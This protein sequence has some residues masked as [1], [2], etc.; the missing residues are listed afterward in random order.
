[1]VVVIKSRK[2]FRA[3]RVFDLTI[4]ELRMILLLANERLNTYDEFREFVYKNPKIT[5]QAIMDRVDQ[6]ASRL[7]LKVAINE[8]GCRMRSKISIKYE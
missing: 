6:M 4:N 1:M 7:Y 5:D 3:R 8:Y 2:L